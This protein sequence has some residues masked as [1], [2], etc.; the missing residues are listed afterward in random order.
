MNKLPYKKRRNL[1][2][3]IQACLASSLVFPI[4]ASAQQ[5]DQVDEII[6]TGSFIRRDNFNQASPL[7]QISATDIEET[8]TVS[9]GDVLFNLSAQ[10]GTGTGDISPFSTTNLRGLGAGATMDLMDGHRLLFGDANNTYPQ[11][12]IDR[13]DILLDGASAL[14]GSEAVAGV[15][16]YIPKKRMDGLEFR[17]DDRLVEDIWEAPDQKWGLVGGWGT[18]DSNFVFAYEYRKRDEITQTDPKFRDYIDSRVNRW[19]GGARNSAG[20]LSSLGPWASMGNP[21]TFDRP[22]RGSDGSISTSSSTGRA[23]RTTTTADPACEFDFNSGG[24]NEA[25]DFYNRNSFRNGILASDGKCN[26]NR[27]TYQNYVNELEQHKAYAY[28]DHQF[29]DNLSM[30]AQLVLGVQDATGTTNTIGATGSSRVSN[31]VAGNRFLVSGDHPGNPFWANVGGNRLYAMDANGDGIADR[32]GSTSSF[33]AKYGGNVVLHPDQFNPNGGGIP[34]HD[35]VYLDNEYSIIGYARNPNGGYSRYADADGNT[36]Q[37]EHTNDQRY[38]LG[39]EY[40]VGDSDWVVNADYIFAN[41]Q[42]NRAGTFGNGDSSLSAIE[43]GLDCQLGELKNKCFNPF[44]TAL[45]MHDADGNPSPFFQTDPALIN[46]QEVYDRLLSPAEQ[47]NNYFQHIVDVVAAGPLPIELQGGPLSLAVGAHYRLEDEEFRPDRLALLEDRVRGSTYKKRLTESVSTDYFF[48]LNAPVLDSDTWGM[49]E[50]SAAYRDTTNDI[51]ADTPVESGSGSYS[52][53]IMKAGIVYQPP[54]VDWISMRAS[55]GEGFVIPEQ[56]TAFGDKRINAST[57]SSTTGGDYT[58]YALIDNPDVAAD[59]SLG[60]AITGVT[61]ADC[62]TAGSIPYNSITVASPSLKAETSEA[63]NVGFS[64]QLLDGRLGIDI[65]R[66]EVDFND[67]TVY[68][69]LAIQEDIARPQYLAHLQNAGC[70]TGDASCYLA[71]RQSWITGGEVAL[72]SFPLS[73]GQNPAVDVPSG[74]TGLYRNEDGVLSDVVSSYLNLDQNTSISYDLKMRYSFDA[75]EIPFIGGDYGSFTANLDATFVEEFT[76]TPDPTSSE[77]LNLAGQLGRNEGLQDGGAP[78][79]KGS[80]GLRWAL[81]NHTA[82]LTARAFQH[83]KDIENN[84]NCVTILSNA[85]CEINSYATFDLFYQYRFQDLMGLQGETTVS[86]TVNNLFDRYPQA[87]ET[88]S[89]PYQ[90]SLVRN[91]FGRYYNVRFQHT[92]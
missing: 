22:R 81:G 33:N 15:V 47:Q 31:T 8:G 58:C 23:S 38:Q 48:E 77:R 24:N 17:F 45:Y 62:S 26:S 56:F 50:L 5:D 72:Q 92:F 91:N 80:V 51:K 18:D 71:A 68:A 36:Q 28:F 63:Y 37:F 75:D 90:A 6:V 73:P 29:S 49:L 34:F 4:Y 13:V 88:F 64:L 54:G 40:L 60:N 16:N 66:F 14:Y 35:D 55:Y 41:R 70:A 67:Q 12:A 43:R 61:T 25:T 46:D 82:R 52:D 11:I 69:S 32:D 74:N 59:P 78:R 7:T 57:T 85:D 30:D 20:R 1:R 44:G 79:W 39:L 9:M 76:I 27:F 3:A 83:V 84:G 53:E 65:D 21:G 10:S 86:L 19:A 42:R 2:F 89:T 87:L